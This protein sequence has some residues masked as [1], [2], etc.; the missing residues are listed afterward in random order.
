M[1]TAAVPTYTMA[2]T[3]CSAVGIVS[4]SSTTSGCLT[5]AGSPAT[6]ATLASGIYG[7][8]TLNLPTTVNPGEF[9]SLTVGNQNETITFNAGTYIFDGTGI[10]VDAT[11]TT[12]TGTGL[13][14]YMTCGSGSTPASCG[15]WTANST[16]PLGGTC[17]STN[18]NGSEVQLNGTTVLNLG[19]PTGTNP[20]LFFFDR[21]NSNQNAFW[22]DSLGVTAGTGYP[23]GML[24]AH[25]GRVMINA[26]TSAIPSPLVVGSIYYNSPSI[27]LGSATGS[28]ALTPGASGP[29]TLVN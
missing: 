6:S 15:T 4:S 18:S 13:T 28:V 25:S 5:V 1:A 12:L 3:N 22:V 10:N 8:V 24:Y 29:G 7:N 21:C 27:V 17:S 14:F 19:G 11:G 16:Q 23:T 9:S 26:S 20:V 2:T